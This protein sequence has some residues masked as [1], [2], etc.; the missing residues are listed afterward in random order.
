[1][2][3]IFRSSNPKPTLKTVRVSFM[4]N[5]GGRSVPKACS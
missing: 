5:F 2:N 1:M 4:A 3:G